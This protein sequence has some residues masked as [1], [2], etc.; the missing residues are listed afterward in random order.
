MFEIPHGALGMEMSGDY[1]ERTRLFSAKSFL[2]NLFAMGT[3]WLIFLAG[4][5]FFRG[6][7]GDL[8]DG[9]RYVSMFIAALLIPMSLWWFVALREPGFAAARKEPKSAFWQDMRTTVSN[10]TFL[11]WWRLF[12]RLQWALIS[13]RSS[14]TT[15][16]FFISTAATL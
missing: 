15:S 8:T 10:T 9:M 12:S 6:P 3:P 2:G 13:S 5:N 4:L 11:N 14:T 7:A 16:R 1:H